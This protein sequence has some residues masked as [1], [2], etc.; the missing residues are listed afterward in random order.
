MRFT[1]RAF[2]KDIRISK[3]TKKKIDTAKQLNIKT[4]KESAW[5]EL[6]NL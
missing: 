2:V 4:I 3:P 1:F 6:L 5:Y